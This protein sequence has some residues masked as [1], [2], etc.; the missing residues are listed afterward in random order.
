M[1]HIHYTFEKSRCGEIV[2]AFVLPDG[3]NK[4]LHSMIDPKREAQ[5]LLSTIGNAGFLVFLGLGG[6]FISEAALELT[7]AQIIVIDFDKDSIAQ[8]LKGRDY[9]KLLSNNRFSL[10]IDPSAQEIKNF[11]IQNYKPALYGG[12]QTIPL[13]TRTE[14][15]QEKFDI[16]VK[17]IQEV[18]E[19]ISGDYS[20][21]SHF[22]FRW[23]S[24]IIR[25]VK[26]T[27]NANEDFFSQTEDIHEA[28]IV[29]AGPSLDQQLPCL[30]E[31]KSRKVYIIS[32]DTAAGILLHNG[33][34]PDVIVTID[35]QFI[36]YYHFLGNKLKNIPLILDIASPPLLYDFAAS[37]VFFCS[38]HPLA[39]Y[40]SANWRHFK[41]LDTSGGN[42]T[43]ACLS[44]AETL[45]AKY[46]TLFGTDF[47]YINS[48]AYA[49][50]TYFYPYFSKRQ[51][52]LL[53]LETQFSAFLYRSPFLPPESGKKKNY[54][55]TSSL[56]FY[57]NKFEEKVSGMSAEIICA[58]GLGVPLNLKKALRGDV[59]PSENETQ[60]IANGE[61]KTNI[62]GVEFLEQYRNDI[63]ALPA[64]Y[65]K[66]NY[67]LKL[68]EK[69]RQIFTTLL[70]L[71]AAIKKRN[72]GIETKYLIEEVKSFS[73]REIE[74]VLNSRSS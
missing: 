27:K 19:I 22:G 49:K 3:T 71:T 12:I 15:D 38:G 32:S 43:Y 14:Q 25:N 4:P 1:N 33:I 9:S 6:G 74:K 23:F 48:Q 68:N 66:E 51:N 62:S 11:F 16:V 13:R 8:L 26:N 40:I 59:I 50:G 45:G 61:K 54:Y 58:D 69:E 72:M 67:I 30:A 34:E 44:L 47:S 7:N 53:P 36:S 55:E 41:Y 28:A 35:C 29:A 60:R 5:R 20:V 63:F 57:R 56:R 42:V 64:A 2:P 18:I 21:Q 46:I 31:L 37:P 65:E 39:Q 52:R 73:V 70:P 17:C 10:L 24:N